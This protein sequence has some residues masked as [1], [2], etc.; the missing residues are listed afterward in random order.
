ML[1]AIWYRKSRDGATNIVPSLS[2]KHKVTVFR[3]RS[4]VERDAWCWAL[5]CEIEKLV[6]ANKEREAKLRDAGGLVE[7]SVLGD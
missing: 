5:G 7:M 2:A 3:T 6:R 1:F 4:K